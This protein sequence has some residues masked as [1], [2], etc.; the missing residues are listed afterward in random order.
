MLRLCGVMRLSVKTLTLTG[1]T[2]TLVREHSDTIENVKTKIQ[3]TE[4]TLA[5]LSIA[6]CSHVHMLSC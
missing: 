2:I 1:K 3:D 6:R 5:Q 4:G